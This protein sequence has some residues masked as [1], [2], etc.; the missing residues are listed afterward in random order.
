M[1]LTGNGQQ[2][3]RADRQHKGDAA[4]Q[5]QI[6]RT[7]VSGFCGGAPRCIGEPRA[8]ALKPRIGETLAD[9]LAQL[10]DCRYDQARIERDR[11][12]V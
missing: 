12:H 9:A 11:G 2:Q 5:D 8:H 4:T 7:D 10:F 6:G 3:G 1:Q